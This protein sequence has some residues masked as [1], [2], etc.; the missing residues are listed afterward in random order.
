MREKIA[1]GF[2]L[3][4]IEQESG[5]FHYQGLSSIGKTT[6]LRVA[7]SV[8]GGGEKGFIQSWRAT[9]NGLEAVAELRN[10]SLLCLD[11]LGQVAPEEIG[12]VTYMLANGTGKT[13]MSKAIQVRPSMDW[14]LVFLST[15]EIS[16][17]DHMMTVGRQ[18]H[19]GQEVRIISIVADAGKGMGCCEDLHGAESADQF[20]NQLNSAALAYYGTPSIAFLHR[21][22]LERD[23]VGE[24]AEALIKKFLE[25]QVQLPASGEV[26]R[27]AR[28]F[29]LVAFAGEYASG[30]GITDRKS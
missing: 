5:G 25:T 30:L 14:R 11:E 7:G 19:G 10:D 3:R 20:A 4:I 28:R 23:K 26:F 29:A 8:L 21:L 15:G 1:E 18:V 27:A 9:S 12:R 17:A 24:K 2:L 16:L 6:L 22:V 13:R